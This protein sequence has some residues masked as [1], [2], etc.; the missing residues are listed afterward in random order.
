MNYNLT[1]GEVEYL[2]TVMQMNNEYNGYWNDP[3]YDIHLLKKLKQIKEEL[4]EEN[5]STDIDA[6]LNC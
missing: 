1:L 2:I 5:I 3:K 4:N 6:A